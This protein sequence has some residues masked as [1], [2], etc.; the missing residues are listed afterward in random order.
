MMLAAQTGNVEQ[1]KQ[2][3]KREVNVNEVCIQPEVVI[4]YSK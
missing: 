1:I 2:L 3:L 4:V